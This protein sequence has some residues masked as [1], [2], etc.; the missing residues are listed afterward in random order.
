MQPS[1]GID[2]Q[3]VVAACLAGGGRVERHR[4]GI[5]PVWTADGGDAEPLAPHLQL[6]GGSRPE[7]VTGC[8]H[9]LA[10][11]PLVVLA[12]FGDGGR[13]AGAVH[14]YDH[15]DLAFQ[16][17]LAAGDIEGEAYAPERLRSE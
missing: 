10:A 2:E 8:E 3:D 7:G 16:L 17:D 11:V 1:G 15:D 9:V 12:Q 6:G 13:L 5:A 14:A 4:A